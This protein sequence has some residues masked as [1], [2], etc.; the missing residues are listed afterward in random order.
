MSLNVE[1]YDLYIHLSTLLYSE[2]DK[3]VNEGLDCWYREGG[4]TG[5]DREHSYTCCGGITKGTS[6]ISNNVSYLYIFI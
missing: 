5:Y 1:D 4:G 3:P 6:Y 2:H